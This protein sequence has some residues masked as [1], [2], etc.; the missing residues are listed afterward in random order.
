M[1]PKPNSD[2][3]IRSIMPFDT[4]AKGAGLKEAAM[5]VLQRHGA[6]APIDE[7]MSWC[8]TAMIPLARRWVG[9]L[10]ETVPFYGALFQWARAGCPHFS[11]TP[12][13]FS[14]VALTDFGDPTDEPL[15]MPFDTFTVSFPPSEFFDQ[16]TKLMVYK[17][18]TILSNDE[19]VIKTLRWKLYRATLLKDDPIFTQWDIGMTRKELAAE[20]EEMDAH[21]PGHGIRPLDAEERPLPLRM[22]S[23][24][25]NVMS[26]IESHGPLPTVPRARKGAVP[27]PVELTHQDRPLYDVGRTVKL[28]GGLRKALLESAGDRERW[29]VSQRFVVRGHW[30]NQAYGEGRQLRRRQ[31]IEPHWKGPENAVEAITRTYEVT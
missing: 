3:V 12:D 18:P 20:A 15:Y 17:L 4:G 16:A 2:D 1:T 7:V 10:E 27:A 21:A 30:R 31:W 6:D 26:Y 19:G 11:L 25:A 23:M 22:R 28:D 29:H 24:L 14:A 5:E 9:T 13:F 8:C